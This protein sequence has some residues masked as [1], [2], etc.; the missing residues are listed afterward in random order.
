MGEPAGRGGKEGSGQETRGERQQLQKR[1]AHGGVTAELGL[2]Q[3]APTPAAG[4]PL[5]Q[6]NGEE[7]Q[8]APGPVLGNHRPSVSLSGPRP[9][10]GHPPS[11]PEESLPGHLLPRFPWAI[12]EASRCSPYLSS[13][14]R[15]PPEAQTRLRAPSLPFLPL[16]S[17]SPG[18]RLDLPQLRALTTPALGGPRGAGTA[19]PASGIPACGWTG[20]G[21]QKQPSRKPSAP[22]PGPV[23]PCLSGL[24]PRGAQA[25]ETLS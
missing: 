11:S 23:L 18:D 7:T 5:L 15:L 25:E 6:C 10:L 20:A 24:G 8:P 22:A 16:H 9:C 3:V 12:P 13:G 14:Q 1:E 4:D 17:E 19:E 21:G 2:G